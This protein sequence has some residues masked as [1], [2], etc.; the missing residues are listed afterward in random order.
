[1]IAAYSP[2]AR[3][4]S[5]RNFGRW[6][7]RLPQ[8]LRQAGVGSLEEANR[9]LRKRSIGE[10]NGKFSGKAQERGTAID[11]YAGKDLELV[12]SIQTERVV[13]KDNTVAIG[14]R[15]WQI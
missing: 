5:E 7:N 9:L 15:W 2:E 14:E 1:M 12:F 13:D 8:E 4:Q 6:Q 11:R 10:C 3:G